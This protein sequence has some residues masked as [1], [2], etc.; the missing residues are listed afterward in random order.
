MRLNLIQS[1]DLFGPEERRQELRQVWHRNNGLFD[2]YRDFVGRPTMRELFTMCIPGHINLIA[3]ADIY[4][5]AQGLRHIKEFYSEGNDHVV[6]CLSRWDVLPD[7]SA[8][9]W[10]HADSADVWIVKGG[11]HE[12][13]T[14]YPLGLAGVDNR[15]AHDLQQAGYLTV[16]P[17]KTI[18]SF[19]LHLVNYRS[20]IVGGKGMGRGGQKIE[21]V[22][23]PYAFVQPTEL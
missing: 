18:Q 5:D 1:T 6:M 23:P 3:N 12:V 20:Y 4:F 9:H 19:H 22:P 7:G 10:D 21:R 2:R 17:S 16:N 13:P 8:K 14:E 15:V 11:P